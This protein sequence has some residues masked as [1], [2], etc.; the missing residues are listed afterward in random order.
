MEVRKHRQVDRVQQLRVADLVHH[1]AQHLAVRL[2]NRLGH[3]L[4]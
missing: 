2:T 1:V 3:H 4:A